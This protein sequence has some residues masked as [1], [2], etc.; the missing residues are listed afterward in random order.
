M[1]RRWENLYYAAPKIRSVGRELYSNDDREPCATPRVITKLYEGTHRLSR[2]VRSHAITYCVW[3]LLETNCYDPDFVSLCALSP[4][5]GY[6]GFVL[7]FRMD[8][9]NSNLTWWRIQEAKCKLYSL[10]L[11][12]EFYFQRIS[13]F[14]IISL[15]F[16]IFIDE[17]VY[18]YWWIDFFIFYISILCL[19][20]FEKNLLT[21][22][23]TCW[24]SYVI[25]NFRKW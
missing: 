23:L 15:L 11:I 3:N 25:F 2:Y 7:T 9:N 20:I 12:R 18:I 4:V 14:A 16:F 17:F 13:Q 24:F 19:N 1:A 6:R 5:K 21:C 10:E 8:K 22:W